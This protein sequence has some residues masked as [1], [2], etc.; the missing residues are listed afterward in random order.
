MACSPT[1]YN[2][3]TP[4]GLPALDSDVPNHVAQGAAREIF[5]WVETVYT[6]ALIALHN[7]APA[8]VSAAAMRLYVDDMTAI[9][10]S[11]IAEARE[12][13]LACRP[14]LDRMLGACEDLI[15]RNPE[16]FD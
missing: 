13:L 15:D 6:H 1:A 5:L 2:C 3:V 8:A 14:A 11:T 10:A 12:R 9:R 4:F 16:A 7:D